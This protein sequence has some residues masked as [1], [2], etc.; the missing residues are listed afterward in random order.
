MATS[1]SRGIVRW[2]ATSTRRSKADRAERDHINAASD[3]S[4]FHPVHQHWQATRILPALEKLNPHHFPKPIR[5]ASRAPLP[6]G[7]SHVHFEVI[8]DGVLTRDDFISL[9]DVSSQVLHTRNPFSKTPEAI[10]MAY[11]VREWVARIRNLM[12]NH[13]I[14]VNHTAYLGYVPDRGDVQMQIATADPSVK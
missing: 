1:N 9:Y 3:R 2:S 14:V 7:G 5:V 12:R 10:Q 8:T 13:T 4:S 11:T 6:S